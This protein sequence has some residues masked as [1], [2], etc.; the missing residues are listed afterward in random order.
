MGNVI[1]LN[2]FRERRDEDRQKAIDAIEEVQSHLKEAR[3]INPNELKQNLETCFSYVF[4][5]EKFLEHINIIKL[6]E[7]REPN[8]SRLDEGGRTLEI[9]LQL[10]WMND[11]SDNASKNYNDKIAEIFQKHATLSAACKYWLSVAPGYQSIKEHASERVYLDGTNG[12]SP[13]VLDI[14]NAKDYQVDRLASILALNSLMVEMSDDE[15]IKYYDFLRSA[16]TEE[17]RQQLD[18]NGELDGQESMGDIKNGHSLR[19]R[20]EAGVLSPLS[21]GELEETSPKIFHRVDT[22]V[23]A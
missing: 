12:S 11:V 6:E 8:I 9:S 5:S 15:V 2:N 7:D 10:T 20:F 14:E 3:L 22:D 19:M 21:M 1:D 23:P 4:G 17:V 18:L 13:L 16:F